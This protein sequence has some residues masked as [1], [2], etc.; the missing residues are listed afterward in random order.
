MNIG[1]RIPA[2]DAAVAIAAVSDTTTATLQI[3]IKKIYFHCRKKTKT[4]IFNRPWTMLLRCCHYHSMIVEVKWKAK[5]DSIFFIH[6]QQIFFVLLSPPINP[7]F[8]NIS[9]VFLH[10][11]KTHISHNIYTHTHILARAKFYC[12]VIFMI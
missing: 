5:L 1:P 4:K 12:H 3:G 7:I 11:I 2:A 6:R 9:A 8:W 10:Q